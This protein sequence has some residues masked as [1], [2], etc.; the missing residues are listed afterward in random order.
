MKAYFNSRYN[1]FQNYPMDKLSFALYVKKV[2]FILVLC[3]SIVDI[4]FAQ[5]LILNLGPEEE[6]LAEKFSPVLHKHP[7]DRQAGLADFNDIVLN[8]STLKAW[9]ILGCSC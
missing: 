5:Q 6:I 2:L 1:R 7:N 3:V 4:L 8:H 9:N